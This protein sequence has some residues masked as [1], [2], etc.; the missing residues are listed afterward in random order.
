[1]CDEPT[2]G[3]DPQS[4]RH[5]FD[6]IK[7]LRDG[8]M[9]I[10]YTTHY[11]EEVEALCDRIAIMDGGEVIACGTLAELQ[12]KHATTDVEIELEGDDVQL[13]AAARAAGVT[14]TDNMLAL[15][16]RPEWSTVIAAIEATGARITHMRSRNANLET[17]FLALTGRSLR[18][19]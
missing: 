10:V 2:V 3:V 12:A 15:E 4:R 5:I 18:D 19:A 16:T 8:G 7:K 11:M 17:V 13:D 6:S 1:V 14:R 9:T